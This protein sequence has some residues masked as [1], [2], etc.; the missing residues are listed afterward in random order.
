MSSQRVGT[1]LAQSVRPRRL[2][3]FGQRARNLL[4]CAVDVVLE[5]FEEGPP[6]TS[7]CRA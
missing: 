6:V 5:G 2:G 1:L 3:Y 7:L 4:F